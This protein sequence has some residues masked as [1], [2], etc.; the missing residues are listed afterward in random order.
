MKPLGFL[1]GAFS[2]VFDRSS[3]FIYTVFLTAYGRV[4][5]AICILLGEFY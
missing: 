3:D 2:I 1:S 5:V 4:A